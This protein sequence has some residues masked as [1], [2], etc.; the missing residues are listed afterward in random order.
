M[1]KHSASTEMIFVEVTNQ[2]Q[3]FHDTIHNPTMNTKHM[4][5]QTSP[6]NQFSPKTTSTNPNQHTPSTAQITP[7]TRETHKEMIDPSEIGRPK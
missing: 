3:Q 4:S 7:N 5:S 6:Q 2:I 1:E